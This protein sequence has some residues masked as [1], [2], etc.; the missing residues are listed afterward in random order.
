MSDGDRPSSHGEATPSGA[1]APV[2][3]GAVPTDLERQALTALRRMRERLQAVEAAQREPIA[4]VGMACRLPGASDAQ[5][6]WALLS[7][8]G[9]AVTT[10]PPERWDAV[11]LADPQGGGAPIPPHAGVLEQV[12][13]FDADFFGIPGREAALLDPQQRLFLEVVWEALEDAGIPALRLRG[14][15]TGVF[16][17]TTASDYLRVI[18]RS[19]PL[20]ALDAYVVSGNTL[21]ATAG[22]VSYLLGLHGP[23]ITMDTACSSGLVAI[24]RAC[25]SL[26]DGESRLA[27][28]GGVNLLLAPE[29]LVSLSRWGM[30]S[31]DGRCKTFDASANGFVRAEGCGVVILKRLSHARADGDRV[32]ALIRGS[33]VNQD[34]PSSGLTVPNGLAQAAV[35]RAAVAAAGVPAASVGYVEAHGTGTTLG[36]PIEMEALASVYGAGRDPAQ[37]LWVGAAKSNIGH[38]EA[39]S[40]VAGL[41]KVVLSLRER[42]IPP[43]VHFREPTPHIPWQQIP[44]R[45]PTALTPWPAIE[46]RRLAGVSAF[47]F[48]GTN[49]HVVLEEAAEEPAPTWPAPVRPQLIT[50]SARSPQA[51]DALAQRLAERVAPLGEAELTALAAAQASSR[52]HLPHRMAV[53]GDGAAAMAARLHQ[54]ASGATEADG[55]LRGRAQGPCRVLFLFTGQGA[56][57]VGMGRDLARTEPVFEAALQRCAAV[58]DPLL[59]APLLQVMLGDSSAPCTEERLHQTA[60]TQPALFAIEFALAALWVAKGL[61]PAAVLGHSVGEFAAAV[62]AGVLP[63]EAAA[64]LVVERGR[65]MQT[66]PAGGAM[67]AVFT[68]EATVQAA[69]DAPGSLGHGRVAVAGINGPQ[70]VVLSGEA[71]ALRDVLAR[72]AIEGVR[73]EPLKVSHAFHSPLMAPIETAFALATQGL[74]PAAPSCKVYST[75]TGALVEGPGF[76]TADYWQRQLRAPVR[77][78]EAICAAL[79][80]PIDAVLEIGPHPVL[81]SLGQRALPQAP[82]PW[83][84]SLRRGREDG[85]TLAQAVAALYVR[86]AVDDHSGQLGARWRGR[87][88]LPHYPFQRVRH[89]VGAA[90]MPAGAELGPSVG[91]AAGAAALAADIRPDFTDPAHAGLRTAGARPL[92]GERLAL[93]NGDTVYHGEAGSAAQAVLHDHRLQGRVVWPGAAS[94]EALLSAAL[95][96][97]AGGPVELNA[98]RFLAPLVLPEAGTVPMQLHWHPEAEAQPLIELFAVPDATPPRH[99]RMASAR[100]GGAAANESA[101]PDPDTLAQA[102]RRCT[103][104]LEPVEFY[105]RLAARGAQFGPAFRVLR[106]VHVGSAEG[107]AIVALDDADRLGPVALHPALLDGCLQLGFLAA[108][109]SGLFGAD[110]TLWVPAGIETLRWW[111]P[112]G[113]RVRC[114]ARATSTPGAAA[115]PRLDLTLWDEQGALVAQ[116]T[117]VQLARAALDAA[118]DTTASP[119]D[120]VARAGYRIAWE[121]WRV[122][123][124]KGRRWCLVAN[125]GEAAD[126]LVRA[127]R[128]TGDECQ[129]VDGLAGDAPTALPA[130]H[131]D[132][133]CLWPAATGSSTDTAIA[134][135]RGAR[136]VQACAAAGDRV[137]RLWFVTQGAQAVL[138]GEAASAEAAALWGLVRVAHTEHSA[139]HLTLVDLP[140]DAPPSDSA[141]LAALL[142][143]AGPLET[144]LALRAGSAFTARLAPLAPTREQ[145]LAVPQPGTIQSLIAQP[146]DPGR[147]G[148]GE[149]RIAVR[150]AG[151]NF[152]DVLC[153]LGTYPGPAT[154]LGGECAGRVVELGEGVT[155]LSVGDEVLAFAPGS[156]A[157]AVCVPAEFAV[158]KPADWTFEQAAALPVAAMTA[159]YALEDLAELAAGERVLIHAAAGGVGLAAVQVARRRGAVVY[160]TAGSEAKRELLRGLGVAQVFDSRSLGFREQVL[161]ATGGEGVHVVLNSLAGDFIAASVDVLARGGRFIEMGKAGPEVAAAM[162]ARRPDMRHVAFDLGDEARRH[163]ALAARLLGEAVRRATAGEATLPAFHRHPMS[164]PHDAMRLMAAGRHSGK[165]VYRQDLVRDPAT[166]GPRADASYLVTGGLGHVGLATARA[167]VERG[168]RHLLLLGRSLPGE[169]AAAT[170]QDL[171]AQGC[172]V[173]V[174]S[175]DICDR[176]ALAATLQRARAHL[177]P[178]RGVVHAAGVL[179]DALLARQDRG[180]LGRSLAPKLAGARHL[181]ELTAA[182]TLDF[183]VVF[184]AGAGWLGPAGQAAYAA[185]NAALDAFAQARHASGRPTLAVAWGRWAGGMAAG[186][187]TTWAANGVG[188]LAPDEALDAM[189]DLLARN[190]PSAALL[191]MEWSRFLPTLGGEA[192]VN[193]FA[194]V[195]PSTRA[196]STHPPAGMP[197]TARTSGWAAEL[198]AT[199]AEQRRTALR[200]RIEAVVRRVVGI[201]SGQALDP[202]T[203]LR[204]L[205]MDSLMTVELRNAIGSAADLPLPTTLVFDHPTLDALTTFL[206]ARLPGLTPEPPAAT[207]AAPGPAAGARASASGATAPAATR[208]AV[209]TM[210]DAEAEAALLRELSTG[211]S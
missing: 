181:D 61:A 178:L 114:H 27:I 160:A 198:A 24:D 87:L 65:L 155:G 148:R 30:L 28:A 207:Q 21:N 117:G 1:T 35:I 68:D 139:L 175:V 40:G 73:S 46:G 182:D 56:Q 159:A 19:V 107:V 81:A 9:D 112:T 193:F 32:L 126:L 37:P 176:E 134:L 84:A 91:R 26:R 52:S 157:S 80:G 136:L 58:M 200:R 152:R 17:G 146:H 135:E 79:Q 188:T 2:A 169:A 110:S 69:L 165:L 33:A 166:L 42:S 158:R 172:T 171:R 145:R 153:V 43:N 197:A 119:P 149:I 154:T 34:G 189:F 15:D 86:G 140:A 78:H 132:V 99:V 111:G 205:G 177:P 54:A 211:N 8:G 196:S 147:P 90:D 36:D 94:V 105:A 39:A 57:Y 138:P 190:Q 161:A 10:L 168:A 162:R 124:A 184:S 47:G 199:P 45:V 88:A 5:D 82:V 141:A 174:E 100:A 93:P 96:Q 85:A 75:L 173:Q 70:E 18:T 23:S 204:E 98:V 137:A 194:H 156:L 143:A 67:A 183:F 74:A 133:V 118:A 101:P 49:V 31:P 167:L 51:L 142:R 129:R 13:R 113:R 60:F 208:A 163:P 187:E 109:E 92:L 59:P 144:Q 102:V 123:D 22:R 210:S 53:L 64:R 66:L 62:V 103:R 89:W 186:H 14:S 63:L 150:A 131:S 206:L 192:P 104:A 130:Q 122:G 16:V 12:D 203:P 20:H 71:A 164:A 95:E 185:A 29:L 55:V 76:A 209:S 97:Q 41:I 202:R 116:V 11:A 7:R 106:E 125:A 77:F 38:L 170:L 44:V 127:L 128:E 48:S 108:S 4:I 72:L 191:P 120:L 195:A 6:Y 115:A 179:D 121:P 180:R 83:L 151:L 50:L 3:P 25:R 201:A